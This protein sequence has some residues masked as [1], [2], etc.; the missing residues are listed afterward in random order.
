MRKEIETNKV[1]VR[2]KIQ[3]DGI[4]LTPIIALIDADYILIEEANDLKMV[5]IYQKDLFAH[6]AHCAASL[7]KEDDL[8]ITYKNEE[9]DNIEV[10]GEE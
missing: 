10:Y 7:F 4:E 5:H 2:M 9:G 6:Y 1:T 3:K 8:I